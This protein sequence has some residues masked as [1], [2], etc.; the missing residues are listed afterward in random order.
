MIV[1][2]LLHVWKLDYIVMPLLQW[3]WKSIAISSI[4][5]YKTKFQ[6][7]YNWSKSFQSKNSMG[8]YMFKFATV[9]DN[10]R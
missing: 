4:I 6:Q 5:A 3:M 2:A 8:E 9:M 10:C 7:P 1:S